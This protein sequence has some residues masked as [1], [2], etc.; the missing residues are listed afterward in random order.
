MNNSII[1]TSI[2]IYFKFQEFYLLLCIVALRKLFENY[3]SKDRNNFGLRKGRIIFLNVGCQKL[4][5]FVNYND[6][7]KNGNCVNMLFILF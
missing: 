3:I 1:K 5:S 7:N 2:R 4:F 6:F